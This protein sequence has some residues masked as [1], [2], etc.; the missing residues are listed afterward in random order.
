MTDMTHATPAPRPLPPELLLDL[1][2]GAAPEP[3]A[4]C[5]ATALELNPDAQLPYAR[6]TAL[7]GAMLESLP[8]ADPVD[9][10]LLARL[11]DRLDSEPPMPEVK[12]ESGSG[13][14]PLALQPYLGSRFDGLQW[15][16]VIGGVEEVVLP[17]TMAGFRTSLLRIAPGRA[18]PQHR[19]GGQ[20]L[21]LVLQGSYDDCN[22]HFGV[23]DLEVA[24][25]EDEHKPVADARMGCICLAVQRAP[26]RLSGFI[27][28]FINPFLKL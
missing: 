26:M 11:L 9:E 4:L 5:V 21:T 28:W 18:M 25:V 17:L 1:A 14:I 3:V 7:G 23:G 20:E 8:V 6:L 12:A 13:D 2:S 22:G 27:G 10:A 15:R 16:Q 24:D 19:H